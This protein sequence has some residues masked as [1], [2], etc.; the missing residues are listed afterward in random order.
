MTKNQLMEMWPIGPETPD[1]RKHDPITAITAVS[2]G[3]SLLGGIFG[4]NAKKKAAD[5][6]AAAFQNAA[7]RT[8]QTTQAVNGDIIGAGNASAQQV[9]QAAGEAT[10]RNDESTINANKLLDPYRESG[11]VATN[12]LTAGLGAGGDFNKTPT[13]ADLQI[14]PGYAFRQQQAQKALE[15]SAAARGG[16][17]GGNAI[18]QVLGLNSNLASQEY[19]NAFNRFQTS[20]QNRF[21]NLN[22][23][24]GRGAQVGNEQGQNLISGAQYGGNL[25][26]GSAGQA[27]NFN[28]NAALQAGQ[29]S[30][31]GTQT[32]NDYLIGK[33]QAQGAGTV[34]QSNALWG[35]I[36]GAANTGFQGV[37]LKN[38]LKNPAQF[39]DLPGGV[40]QGLPGGPLATLGRRP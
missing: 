39:G 2:A 21:N 16:A 14:D 36:T 13:M 19:Q 6:Q 31:L 27:A 9:R 8:D 7:A 26:Y 22:T 40:N 37:Q 28:N 35:G 30:I 33:S 3:T 10:A 15:G 5:Q 20:T 25:N 32:A 11:D 17:L 12:Q 24:A 34:G 29:N 1:H 4:G 38:L 23:V 18:G